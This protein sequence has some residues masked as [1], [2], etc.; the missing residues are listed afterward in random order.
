VAYPLMQHN[1]IF[2]THFSLISKQNDQANHLQQKTE[3]R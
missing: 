2:L 1:I 3:R